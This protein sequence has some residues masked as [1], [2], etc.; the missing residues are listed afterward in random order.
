MALD[1]PFQIVGA[2]KAREEDMKD[3]WG[4]RMALIHNE[5]SIQS[6][7]LVELHWR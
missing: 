2:R 7:P 5:D 3:R 6:N 1:D 4:F